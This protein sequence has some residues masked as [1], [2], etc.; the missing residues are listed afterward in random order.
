MRHIHLAL[1]AERV[2]LFYASSKFSDVAV[3]TIAISAKAENFEFKGP[4]APC[5]SCR[6]VMAETENGFIT[7]YD[8]HERISGKIYVVEGVNNLLPWMFIADELKK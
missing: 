1:C 5:G 7:N 8:H 3:K 2:A 6:Q 4:V